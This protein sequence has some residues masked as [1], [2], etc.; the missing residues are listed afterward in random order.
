M[1]VIRPIRA[2][3]GEH[4]Y[5]EAMGVTGL[6]LA[7]WLAHRQGIGGAA[8]VLWVSL[9]VLSSLVIWRAGDFFAPASS[10]IQNH[11][12]LPQSIKAA[13]IDAVASS[14][15][16]FCVAVIAT[17]QLGKAEVGVSTIIGSALYNVL[18]IPAAVGLVATS[19]IKVGKD[20][21]WRDNVFYLA[22]VGLLYI[23]L[24]QFAELQPS[25]EV[26]TY[27]GLGVALIFLGTYLL[28]VFWLQR[29]YRKYQREHVGEPE[30][31][32]DE[33][34]DED[35]IKITSEGGA[36]MWIAGM[37]ILMGLSTEVLVTSAINLGDLLTISPVVMGF[38]IIAAGTSVPDTALSVIS[39]QRGHYDAAISNV[40]GSNIFDICI[41][42]SVPVLIA[43]TISGETLIDLKQVELVWALIGATLLS[44]YF[45]WSKN[46]TLSKAKAGIMG[47]TYLMI[48]VYV[49]SSGA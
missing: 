38:V 36:W 13:V 15:P 19:P 11:H 7:A 6:A 44:F 41:C 49:V 5:K 25:G 28:Y 16:E 29:D 48:V 31:E 21:V 45:F 35:P 47:L 14:F 9:I 33:D 34:E 40:F 24:T 10:F 46:Y 23:M 43:L 30:P 1:T 26:Q 17:I 8:H 20:V 32:S 12:N 22:V 39:A 2:F 27:W 3:F 37:M 42:L 4:M 18:V